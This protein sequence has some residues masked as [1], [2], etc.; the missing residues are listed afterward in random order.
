[1]VKPL[2]SWQQ[3]TGHPYS[4]NAD[5]PDSQISTSTTIVWSASTVPDI[6][7][8]SKPLADY[9]YTLIIFLTL[10]PAIEQITRSFLIFQT[11]TLL[12]TIV[13]LKQ[14]AQESGI[15]FYSLNPSSPNCQL[16]ANPCPSHP[17]FFSF[18]FSFAHSLQWHSLWKDY[19][20]YSTTTKRTEE[21]EKS[22]QY[23]LQICSFC[24]LFSLFSFSVV[25][26]GRCGRVNYTV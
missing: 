7:Q 14:H 8:W 22:L 4:P 2:V 10:C 18:P 9:P 1:M 24:L 11:F 21:E 5:V 12:H 20:G 15:R 19:V 6:E 3:W 25:S 13:K 23:C 26:V 16:P 17:L